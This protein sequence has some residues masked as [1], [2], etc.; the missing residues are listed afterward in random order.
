[1]S[2]HTPGEYLPLSWEQD[3]DTEYVYGHIDDALFFEVIAAYHGTGPDE[4]GTIPIYASPSRRVWARLVFNGSDWDGPSRTLREYPTPGPGRF[5][6][7]AA[8]PDRWEH[9]RRCSEGDCWL[10]A[11]HSGLHVPYDQW[12]ARRIALRGDPALVL[13]AEAR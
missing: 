3:P 11:G 9:R 12:H 5:K 4:F 6:V 13:P 8:D 1:M 2:K 7:T 10:R